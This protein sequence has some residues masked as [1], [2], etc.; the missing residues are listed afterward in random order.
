ML[1]VVGN[2]SIDIILRGVSRLPELSG[3]GTDAGSVARITEPVLSMLGGSGGMTAFAAAA[4]GEMVRLWSSVGSDP[5]GELAL[6]WL[7]GRH[8]DTTSVRI[9]GD[10]G[11]STTILISGEEGAGG[12]LYYA[13]VADLFAPRVRAVGGGG[14]DWLLVTG[15]AQ[16]PMWRGDN[17]LE[18]LRNARRAG[19]NTAL[20]TGPSFDKP[21]DP[22]ELEPLLRYTGVLLS[23][24]PELQALSKTKSLEKAV[25]WIFE[26]GAKSL[27]LREPAEG[28]ILFDSAD[29]DGEK[30]A[31]FSNQPD[32]GTAIPGWTESF[33]AGFLFARGRGDSP[34][35]SVRFGLACAALVAGAK[36]GSLDSPTEAAVRGFL[37]KQP[38][39]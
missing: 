20:S 12:A 6:N 32:V 17:T 9:S 21:V 10:A 37:D 28:T 8:V 24:G 13:G 35:D 19:V 5:L 30:V 2:T 31:P 39:A 25:A 7:E 22:A 3:N 11:T 4:L 16:M 14:T 23:D 34:Q 15:Y 26:A 33:D 38:E 29:S 18:L 27:L 36:R 1:T